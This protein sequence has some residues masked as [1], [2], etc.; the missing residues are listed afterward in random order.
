MD[1]E[2]FLDSALMVGILFLVVLFAVLVS[3][4]VWNFFGPDAKVVP[5]D[6]NSTLNSEEHL[7]L[8]SN[9][10]FIVEVLGVLQEQRLCGTNQFVPDSNRLNEVPAGVVYSCFAPMEVR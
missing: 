10:S 6:F 4:F 8:A 7:A 5:G 9:Q 3:F 1:F 2:K